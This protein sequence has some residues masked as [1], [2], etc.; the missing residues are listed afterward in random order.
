MFCLVHRRS[1]CLQELHLLSNLKD[2]KA[3]RTFLVRRALIISIVSGV[4]EIVK[5]HRQSG[6]NVLD[7][8]RKKC[9]CGSKT[10]SLNQAFFLRILSAS[11][12]RFHDLLMPFFD[13]M[14]LTAQPTASLNS[15][16]AAFT[17]FCGRR[18]FLSAVLAE[19]ITCFLCCVIWYNCICAYRCF[20]RFF[21]N[22]CFLFRI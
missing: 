2:E 19:N 18:Y 10:L 16:S 6:V 11:T 1:F 9:T 12:E 4:F 5:N 8:T 22:D 13:L 17:E 3:L 14:L 21:N 20:N 7:F 15:C